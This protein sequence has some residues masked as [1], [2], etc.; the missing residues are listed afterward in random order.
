M[1]DSHAHY[2]DKV[3]DDDRENL[4]E[5]IKKE[6]SYVINCGADINSSQSSVELADKYNFIFA[7]VGIHPENI[8]GLEKK[9]YKDI[10]LKLKNMTLNKKVKAIGEIGLDFHYEDYSRED[11]IFWFEKQI[12]LAKDL[13]LPV[14]IHSRDAD[15]DCFEIIKSYYNNSRIAGVIHCYSSDLSLALDYLNLNFCLGVGGIITFKKSNQLRDVIKEI[16]LNKILL[17]TDC[18]Y[19]SPEPKRGERNNSLNLNF[20]AKKISEIK[21]ISIEEVINITCDSAKKLFEI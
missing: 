19:L 13:S 12:E 21:N 20:V 16:P 8:V 15:Q 5:Q 11:Q 2:D 7:A 3:F 18:P 9:N 10:I 17:E 14:I 6:V 4:L 1:F